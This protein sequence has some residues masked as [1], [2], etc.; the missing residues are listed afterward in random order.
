MP[1]GGDPDNRRDFPG[2][3][4][5]DSRNAFTRQG[6]TAVENDVFDHLRNLARL[7]ASSAVLR[8][9][10]LVQL[11]DEEQQTAFA[12]MLGDEVAIIAFNNDTKPAT[13][14]IDVSATG[15]SENATPFARLSEVGRAPRIE[16]GRLVLSLPPRVASVNIWRLAGR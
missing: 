6:R 15:L 5:G 8:R 12:R 10:S 1:G 3:F 11:Y 9:G 13:L 4:P 2:G 14:D 7:R 16:N